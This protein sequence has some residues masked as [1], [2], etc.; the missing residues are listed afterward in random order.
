M[1]GGTIP[2]NGM[3]PWFNGDGAV[4]AAG[5]DVSPPGDTADE[6]KGVVVDTAPV[7]SDYK[8][9]INILFKSELGEPN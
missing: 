9:D 6:E 3:T 5:T 2:G 7:L 4:C 1:F 8:G